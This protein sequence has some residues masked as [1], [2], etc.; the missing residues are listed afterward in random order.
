MPGESTPHKLMTV[1]PASGDR[2]DIRSG[3]R[4]ICNRFPDQYWRELDRTKSYASEFVD[5]LSRDG[6]LSVLIPAEYGGSGLGIG[7][8]SVILQEI[9]R[10]GGNSAAAHAQMY[11]M[12]T[13][14]RHG[15]PRQKSHYLPRI[16]SGEMRLQAFAVTEPT[17]GSETTH[18]QTKAERRGGEYVI[19]GQKVFISRVEYSDLM[20]LAAR[21]TPY[22]DVEDKTAGLSLFLVELRAAIASGQIVVRPIEMMVNHS[23]TELFLKDLVVPDANLIGQEGQGFRYLLDGWNAERILIAAECVGDGDWFVDRAARYSS[24]RVIFGHPI[25]ANQ[26]VQLPIAQAYAQ[27][28][29]AELMMRQAADLFDKGAPCGAE[30][31]MAKLLASQASWVAANACLDAHGGYGFATEFDV[32][33]KFRE[34]RLYS[35]APVNNN[36]VLAFL[37]QHVLGMPRSY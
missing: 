26:G 19:N 35:V 15:S 37:G 14:L 6:W 21:T 34:T 4:A 31:N 16:A 18:I 25:G 3:I 36:L 5:A 22:A 13:L 10:S 27:V 7:D 11:V 33:R 9:N 8:A 24:Q 23:T 2:D 30:A 1:A 32:E 20:L 12:G 29:A 28:R 17:S